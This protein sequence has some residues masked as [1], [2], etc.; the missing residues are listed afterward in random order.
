MVDDAARDRAIYHA[1][2]AADEVATVPIWIGLLRRARPPTRSSSCGRPVSAWAKDCELSRPTASR[3]L[4]RSR[5]ATTDPRGPR[6]LA[7]CEHAGRGPQRSAEH[8]H[9]PFRLDS[10]LG[11][12]GGHAARVL[13]QLNALHAIVILSRYLMVAAQW[14]KRLSLECSKYV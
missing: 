7:P 11:G 2:K 4:T 5:C 9:R 6:R 10:A 13:R 14:Q 3:T 1:L 8:R 12:L